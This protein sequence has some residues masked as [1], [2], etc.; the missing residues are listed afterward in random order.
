MALLAQGA[1]HTI[2]VL[3]DAI[4]HAGLAW[5]LIAPLAVYSL[6]RLLT[7]VFVRAAAQAK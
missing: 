4:L 1:G 3:R 7:P 5:I 6:Y 2:G